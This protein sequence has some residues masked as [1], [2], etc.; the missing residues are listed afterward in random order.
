[1]NINTCTPWIYCM[2]PVSRETHPRA[3]I[4]RQDPNSYRYKE[5]SW[6]QTALAA[7]LNPPQVDFDS[8]LSKASPSQSL[9]KVDGS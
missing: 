2:H 4:A 5:P 6:A 3:S 1:M 7:A 8:E 9:G